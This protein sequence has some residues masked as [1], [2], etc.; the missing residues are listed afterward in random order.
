MKPNTETNNH[1]DEESADH[2]HKRTIDENT[3]ELLGLASHDFI[4]YP[5]FILLVAACFASSEPLIYSLFA[6]SSAFVVIFLLKSFPKYLHSPHLTTFTKGYGILGNIF[7]M[8]L[9]FI[10]IFMK[11]SSMSKL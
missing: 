2:P 5:G 9:Q 3:K 6:L 4:Y 7:L 11:F 10:V 8:A 1:S